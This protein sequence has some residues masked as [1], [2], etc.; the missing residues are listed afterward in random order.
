LEIR[1]ALGIRN[2][3]K[4]LISA[5]SSGSSSVRMDLA[6]APPDLESISYSRNGSYAKRAKRGEK[7]EK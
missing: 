6:K 3:E 1:E 5:S 2:E 7:Y 4:I